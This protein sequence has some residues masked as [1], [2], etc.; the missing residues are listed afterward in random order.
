MGDVGNLPLMPRYGSSR[1]NLSLT[2]A[3]R[4]GCGPRVCARGGMALPTVERG[5]GLEPQQ[6]ILMMGEVPL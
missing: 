1:T 4:R 6:P 5:A 2:S 3:G